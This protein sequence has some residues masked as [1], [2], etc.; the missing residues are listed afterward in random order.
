MHQPPLQEGYCNSLSLVTR[1]R[2]A[3]QPSLGGW[4]G[5]YCNSLLSRERNVSNPSHSLGAG[6]LHPVGLLH[7]CCTPCSNPAPLGGFAGRS[8]LQPRP[9]GEV[10]VLRAQP[11]PFK[12]VFVSCSVQQPRPTRPRGGLQLGASRI[13]TNIVIFP[14]SHPAGTP[15][16][17]T[18]PRPRLHHPLLTLCPPVLGQLA[19]SGLATWPESS[20]FWRKDKLMIT[21][22]FIYSTT[23]RNGNR[24]F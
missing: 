6:L 18:R 10:A 24:H 13:N 19:A 16:Q 21:V 15:A 7:P 20:A 12:E 5:G 2:N 9:L 3:Q 14:A 17:T 22:K 4:L 23:P 1:E 8:V 11:C